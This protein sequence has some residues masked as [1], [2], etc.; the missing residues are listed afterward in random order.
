MISERPLGAFLSGGIDSSAVV[1]AMARQASGPVKTFSI[2]FE[3]G[4]FDERAHAR[5]LAGYYGTEHQEFVVTPAA[6]DVLP[7]LAWHFGEPFADSSAIP[8]F[9]VAQLSS[10]HVTVVLTGDGGDESF[11]G[12]RRYALMGRLG[13]FPCP[14]WRGR[15]CCTSA[16]RSSR[17]ANRFTCPGRRAGHGHARPDGTAALRPHHVAVHARAKTRPV[18]GRNARAARRRGQL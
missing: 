1:A 11:G 15:G 2:G 6:L 8:S 12:Y 4:R 13:V 18:Y 17:A 5:R 9:Y 10:Q 14:D 3:D 7:T 16:W